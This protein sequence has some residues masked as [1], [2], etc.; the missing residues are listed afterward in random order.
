MS[1]Q[2]NG[3]GKPKPLDLARVL[4]DKKLVIVGGTGFLGKVFWS[5]LL[6]HYP[7]LGRIYLVVRAKG[8]TSAEQRFWNEIATSEVLRPLRDQHG[9][10]YESWL[11][12]K[13]VPIAGDVI[14]PFCGLDAALRDDLRGEID[15]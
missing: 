7:N 15:A 3:N 1:G 9:A 8:D 4:A 10:R 6:V 12:E 2:G 11:R 13:V 14:K 5:L